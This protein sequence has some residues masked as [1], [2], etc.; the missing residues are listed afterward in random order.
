MKCDFP[1]I[2]SKLRRE[3]GISQKQ[4]A[5]DLGVS[6]ALLSHYEKGI[7]E[8]GLDFLIGAADY[9]GVT[10][11]Y[12]LGKCGSVK[13]SAVAAD[14]SDFELERKTITNAQSLIFELLRRCE[15]DDVGKTGVALIKLQTFQAIL[16]IFGICPGDKPFTLPSRYAKPA[17]EGEIIKYFAKLGLVKEK[18]DNLSLP[19]VSE[20][21]L[22]SQYPE[23]YN[24]LCTL[25]ASVE[26]SLT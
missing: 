14:N 17:T 16:Y 15:K 3:R 12:L 26:K 11:D 4:A 10:T 19:V 23:L 1:N 24:D 22:C 18:N 2:L 9:F 6:Q 25:I 7:R 8:C 21:K 13:G 20:E 5:L